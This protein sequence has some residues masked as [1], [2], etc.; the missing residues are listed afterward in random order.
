MCPENRGQASE[1]LARR[2]IAHRQQEAGKLQFRQGSED[3]GEGRTGPGL[4]DTEQKS[5]H[6]GSLELLQPRGSWC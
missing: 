6:M 2:G 3:L 1:G 4:W 5:L